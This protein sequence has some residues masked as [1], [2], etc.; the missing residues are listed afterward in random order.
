MKV[1]HALASFLV[2]VSLVLFAPW[3]HAAFIPVGTD[4]Q[5][6]DKPQSK[7]WFNDGAWW[8]ILPDGAGMSFYKLVNGTLVKQTFAGAQIDTRNASRADVLS[9]GMTLYVLMYRGA[10]TSKLH[11]FSYN[12]TTKAYTQLSGF[13]VDVPLAGG[14]ESATLAK[15]STG[16]LWIAYDPTIPGAT[17]AVCGSVTNLPDAQIRV[18]WSADHTSWSAFNEV[19]VQ[20][21]VCGDDLAAVVAFNGRIGVMWSNQKA[22]NFGFRVHVD[23]DP[24]TTWGPVETF[25][26]NS[27][28]HVHLTV[29]PE[30]DI[31]AATK[32]EGNADEINLYMRSHLTNKWEGPFFIT[33]GAT[34]PVVVYDSD[35]KDVYV[36]YTTTSGTSAIGYKR[37]QFADLLF[38]EP[39]VGLLV[40]GVN[41]DDATSTKQVVNAT[42]GLLVAAKESDATGTNIH[43]AFVTFNHPPVAIAQASSTSGVAPLAVN[44]TGS[45]SSDT[46]GSIQG[47][48][49]ALGD[50]GTAS[51]ANPSHTYTAAGTYTA[52]LTVTDNKGATGQATVNITVTGSSTNQAPVVNAGP[53][54]SI[55]LPTNSVTLNGS[56]T[57]DGKP[58]PPAKVTATWSKQSGPGTVTFGNLNSATTTASFSAAGTY[59]LRLTGS[60]S[61]LSA[62]DDVAITVNSTASTNKPPVVSAGSDQTIT[63]LSTTLNGSVTDDGLPTGS[64]LTQ[65]W[66]MISGPGTV[67]FGP[68]SAAVTTANFSTAGTYVLRLSASDS[69]L[70]ASDDVTVMIVTGGSTTVVETRVAAKTDDA[71]EKDSGGSMDLTSSNVGLGT[72]PSGVHFLLPVPHGAHIVRA[73]V[74]F[75]AASAQTGAAALMIEGEA[76][77]NA[78]T[79]GSSKHNIANRLRTFNHVSW[80]P[81]GWPTKGAA[82]LDQQTPD[83]SA[84]MQEIVDRPGWA[85]GQG[86]VLIVTGTGVRNAVSYDTK[87]ATAALL[88]VEYVLP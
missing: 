7:L 66:S 8:G 19:V 9:D 31:L 58:N 67:T 38:D 46:D 44:F 4:G 54:Q 5:T 2:L 25:G 78:P 47:Y 49:W 72:S 20:T 87:P 85:S 56:V 18:L 68:P 88:H 60:D 30:Q 73:Y 55:T 83:L 16:K 22:G 84:I 48:Q 37:A 34:R 28:D 69:A 41:L 40:P 62:F 3:G 59:V 50:G 81:A 63:A 13:P 10:A 32:A 21:P 36:V 24:E 15:D 53:D 17:A 27:D 33:S 51:V 42:T 71:E 74:Q 57:D 80:T 52:R 79:F 45:G 14:K 82:G 1:K 76:S 11:K 86:V 75:T 29:T 35:N 77:D 6:T 39:A 23:G 61:L 70:S 26:T 65:S 12:P 43:Y 64:T